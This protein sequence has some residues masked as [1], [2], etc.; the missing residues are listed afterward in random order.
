M[1]TLS[2]LARSERMS[3][4]RSA[5]TKPEI[6]LRKLVWKLG[7]RYRKNAVSIIG[8]PDIAF[9]RRKR[10]IFL[11]GCFW[12]RHDCPN[13]RRLPKSRLEFWQPK[14]ERNV[15]RD[16]EVGERLKAA[17]WRALVVWECQMRNPAQVEQRVREFLDA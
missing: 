6:K 7:H 16:T 14:F 9:V 17:G 12:H 4:V 13:G 15:A 3:L 8:T 11:H 10:A 5:G 2:P 1:D